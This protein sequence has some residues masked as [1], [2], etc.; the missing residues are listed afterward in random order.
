MILP[1]A[2]SSAAVPFVIMA[3]AGQGASVRQ[4][5]IPLRPL[6][7]LDRELHVILDNL[8]PTKRTSAGLR[9]IQTCVFILPRRGRRGFT[10]VEQLQEHIDAFIKAYNETA[11][12]FAWTKKKVHQR[13]FKNRRITQ[14]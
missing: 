7:C 3:P 8:A 13:R 14:L 1:M 6:Q 9:N 10:A 4:L 2:T 12:P 11:E 5:Q